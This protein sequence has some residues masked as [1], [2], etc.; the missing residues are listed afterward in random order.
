MVFQVQP[1]RD[2]Y[3]QIIEIEQDRPNDWK[4]KIKDFFLTIFCCCCYK[5]PVRRDWDNHRIYLLRERPGY[6]DPNYA[7]WERA[8]QRV[9]RNVPFYRQIDIGY[10]PIAVN[11][12]PVHV[13]PFYQPPVR[14][15]REPFFNWNHHREVAPQVKAPVILNAEREFHGGNYVQPR[16]VP[17]PHH[18]PA[19][20]IFPNPFVNNRP[21]SVN[22][23]ALNQRNVVPMQ[24][25]T[26]V[27]PNLHHRPG[28]VQPGTRR[29]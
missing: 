24:P 5:D 29:I 10:R 13:Q 19:N 11:P 7:V 26:V 25:R 18:R 3:N 9:N 4:Q 1:A 20:V 16:V 8:V 15:N 22:P 12:L 6:D 14:V 28:S 2:R 21:V 27:Q 23:Y 17:Q